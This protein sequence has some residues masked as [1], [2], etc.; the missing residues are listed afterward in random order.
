MYYGLYRTAVV[1]GYT[2]NDN[3]WNIFFLNGNVLRKNNHRT[4]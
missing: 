4:T 2:E 3:R 1:E